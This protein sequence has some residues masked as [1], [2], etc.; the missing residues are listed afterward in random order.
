MAKLKTKKA[1]TGDANSNILVGTAGKDLIFG[2]DG[3]DFLEGRHGD[4]DLDGG[5]GFDRAIYAA[6]EEA[7][8]VSLATGVVMGGKSSGTDTL[9]S[10]EGIRGTAF[11]DTYDATGFTAA[12]PNGGDQGTLNEFEGMGGDDVIT[13]NGNTRISY[14]SA[15]GAVT[16]DM[17][18]G[19][20][21]GDAS[22]GS[23]SFTGVSNVRGSNFA[24]TLL[25]SNND[26]AF[27][28]FTENFEGRA[29]NDFIDGRGGIDRALYHLDPNTTSGITVNLAAGTVIGDDSVGTDT[30]RSVEFARGTNFA[31]LFVATGFSGSSTNAG[32][33]GSFNEF[34]GMGGDDVVVG[35]GNTRLSYTTATAA[36][37]VNLALGIAAGNASVGTDTFS[38]VRDVRGS[39]FDDT[40]IGSDNGDAAFENFEGWRGDDF[41]DGAGGIDRLRYVADDLINTGIPLVLGVNIDLGAGIVTG[42]DDIAQALYGTDTLHSIEFV[43]GTNADDIFEA[44]GFNGGSA[45]AG[46][47]FNEFEGMGG[48]DVVTGNGNTRISFQSATAA[49]TVHLAAGTVV[50]DQSVGTDTITGGVSRVRGSGFDD[51]ITGS[52]GGDVL[53][54]RAGN[55]VLRGKS[56]LDILQGGDGDDTLIGGLNN[57]TLIGEAGDDIFVYADGFGPELIFGF[58]AG[59]G[60]E[61]RIDLTGVAGV[62]DFSDLVITQDGADAVIHFS[63]TGAITLK[64]LNKAG[65]PRRRLHLR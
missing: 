17:A 13:G 51:D 57:D 42:R 38:N 40:L 10:I 28:A 22:I 11:A 58:V 29:G 52:S 35:N 20:A 33:N 60:T 12:S 64:N 34:E 2:L 47:T 21:T 53:E 1:I 37:T 18:A 9:A 16:V 46:S 48:D 25:G 32:S 5:Q 36:V 27:P 19:T 54:G 31:D 39:N 43:Q 55:D 24:D 45:G 14:L 26:A 56:G 3:N 61:D 44:T 15:A 7:I 62:N 41:I 50:G 49:V 30:L 65:S 63:P 6:A 59:A 4:D 23:D 8:W